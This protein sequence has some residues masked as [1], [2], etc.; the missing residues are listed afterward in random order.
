MKPGKPVAVPDATPLRRVLEQCEPL[1]R[2]QQRL[3][4]AHARMEAIRALLPSGLA[5]FVKPGPVED[6]GWTL[7]A[8]GPAVAAKLRQMQPLLETALRQQGFEVSSIRIRVQSAGR[9]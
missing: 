9:R 5:P 4:A 3:A 7:F 2:L 1:L 6:S 8:T